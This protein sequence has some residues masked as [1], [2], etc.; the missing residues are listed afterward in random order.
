ML[1][2]KN[3]QRLRSYRH[4]KAL[5]LQVSSRSR[6]DV[7]LK[8]GVDQ[9][10]L[11][12]GNQLRTGVLVYQRNVGHVVVNKRGIHGSY[13][14]ERNL[15][16]QRIKNVR[17]VVC[18]RSGD[19]R[20]RRRR[21]DDTGGRARYRESRVRDNHF[22]VTAVRAL[23]RDFLNKNR[24]RTYRRRRVLGID[25]VSYHRARRVGGNQTA[26]SRACETNVRDLRVRRAVIRLAVRNGRDRKRLL[27]DT[28]RAHVHRVSADLVEVGQFFRSAL[29]RHSVRLDCRRAGALDRVL[30]RDRVQVVH[31]V[32]GPQRVRARINRV[33]DVRGRNRAVIHLRVRYVKD[34]DTLRD[35]TGK[36]CQVRAVQRV[37][38]RKIVRQ[39]DSARHDLLT[40]RLNRVCLKSAVGYG[41]TVFVLIGRHKTRVSL[42][43]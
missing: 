13:T 37:V 6:E 24:R 35:R 14:V 38:L 31:N 20:D 28:A 42:S 9:L 17:T 12:A 4:S 16:V 19:L 36:S 21:A 30:P 39:G 10:N 15:N 2:G 5:A 22:V 41:I 40:A 3:L 26:V 1:R 32:S 11:A 27:R 23:Q 8:S 25:G 7:V 29:K 33:V 43:R 34:N 18:L